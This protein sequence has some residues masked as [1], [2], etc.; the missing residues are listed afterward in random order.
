MSRKM[1]FAPALFAMITGCSPD[2]IESLGPVILDVSPNAG[3]QGTVVTIEGLNFSENRTDTRV[4]IGGV[5]AIVVTAT[6]TRI[7]AIVG[8]GTCG[9]PVTVEVAGR[10]TTARKDFE[11]LDWPS[12][13]PSEDG[14]P[15]FYGGA[16]SG[17]PA[18]LSTTG[19]IRALVVVSYPTD[20]L[21]SDP[22]SE[23]AAIENTWTWLSMFYFQ[24]SYGRLTV[25]VTVTDWACLTGAFTDYV[26]ELEPGAYMFD[27]LI[28][29]RLTA[30][31]AQGALDQG[32]DLENFDV[33]CCCVWT[34][35]ENVRDLG[36][37]ND[38]HFAYA[39]DGL[40]INITLGH[41]LALMACHES[42]DWGGFAH[43]LGHDLLE[44]G[45]VLGEDV[46]GQ[47][48]V[49]PDSATA[50]PFDLMGMCWDQPLFSGHNLYQLGWFDEAN[51]VELNW[52][53][54]PFSAEY[55]LAAHR[56]FEDSPS[57]DRYHLVRIHVSEGLDYYVEVRQRPGGHDVQ[58]FD[59]NIHLNEAANDG[60]VVVTK[61]IT[62][63]LNNNQ[64]MRLITLLHDQRVLTVG[65]VA[66][67][68]ERDLTIT[69]TAEELVA[70]GS[71]IGNRLVST[72]RIAW[73]QQLEPDPE[74]A[75]DLWIEPWGTG[76]E[77]VDI[78][79]DRQ[80]WG[81][82]DD[83]DVDGDPVGNGD[84]PQPLAINHFWSR[85]HCDGS[86]AEN[87]RVT[88][89]TI[90][91]PGV[92]DNGTWTPLETVELAISANTTEEQPVNWVPLVGE[93]T[94]LQVIVEPQ[95]GENNYANNKAQ[96][97]VFEFEAPASSVP[98]PIRIPL[99]VRNPTS[100]SV[101]VLLKATGVP[102]GYLVQL[103]HHWV[104]LEPL[105]E[106]QLE[107]IV[108]PLYDV[109]QYSYPLDLA[110]AGAII[111]SYQ[112]G[113]NG[114]A[115]PS[116]MM[117]IGGFVAS[118]RPKHRVAIEL[119]E[120]PQTQGSPNAL[121]LRGSILQPYDDQAVQVELTDPLGRLRVQVATTDSE[122]AFGTIFDLT[123]A[124]TEDPISGQPGAAETP[125][126]GDYKAR[127]L[128]H[129]ATD[130]A[131]TESDEVMITK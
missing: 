45:L 4:A 22:D 64:Q 35:G 122:G 21:P 101:A 81:V 97:N 43:E 127:A 66:T 1:R 20:R 129:N 71:D 85:V 58:V 42:D 119:Y 99:A 77:T 3:Y 82:F 125:V 46:Y 100:E 53:R 104:H 55:Q 69:V 80:P 13:S 70:D 120:D 33:L 9:G 106:V 95:T 124:P 76:C 37:W 121:G 41:E 27:S 116:K 92:G 94:C 79:I 26:T 83:T 7:E 126:A 34:N 114:L 2:W 25:D 24:A 61:V 111:R 87:V 5:A 6:S 88:F 62:G 32:F 60:G 89:Y 44:P 109:G 128:I 16:G 84:R 91:P 63:E 130:V 47:D 123:N 73:A 31:C 11:L 131:Q 103:P 112:T 10:T 78:W 67:D 14:P 18:P 115:P 19:T 52:D 29:D 90:S 105:G 15:I 110:I 28:L 8:L 39:G 72:V 23:R 75:F 54:D 51:V 40:D 96:E 68:P 98:A 74:S 102:E 86:D 65:D 48:L 50:E 36:N 57:N 107:A 117:R 113:D 49:D 59:A 118:V 38:S 93:H 30:E 108:V 12:A 17:S 56:L